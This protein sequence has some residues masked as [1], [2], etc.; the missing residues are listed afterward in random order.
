MAGT[1]KD[2]ILAAAALS[3]SAPAQWDAFMLE[4]KAYADRKRDDCVQA[5]VDTL[6]VA[7]GRAQAVSGIL[8][9]MTEARANSDKIEG[10]R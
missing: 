4:L 8:K 3:R 2:F 1:Q 7:Q 5:T 9:E 10:R 6:Q